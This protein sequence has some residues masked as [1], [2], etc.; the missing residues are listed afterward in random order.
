MNAPTV[1]LLSTVPYIA[2]QK[3]GK[4][5]EKKEIYGKEEQRDRTFIGDDQRRKIEDDE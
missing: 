4:K 3:E 2:C 1:R 5:E